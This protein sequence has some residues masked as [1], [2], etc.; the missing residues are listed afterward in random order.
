MVNDKSEQGML[1][2]EKKTYIVTVVIMNAVDT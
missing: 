2:L 1:K